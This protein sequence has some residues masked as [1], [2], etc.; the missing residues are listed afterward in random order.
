MSKKHKVLV[1][2][3][4]FGGV[5]A[6]QELS[7]DYTLEVTLLS[8]DSELRYYPTLF[9]TATGGSRANSSIPFTTIFEGYNLTIKKGLATSLDRHNKT[10]TTKDDQVFKYDTL[11]LA[12]GVVTNYFN[13]EGMKEYSYS[14][15]SQQEASE[16]KR[17]IHKQLSQTHRPDPNYIV[18]GAGPTGIE[19]A[20]TLPE[21]I[22]HVM[23]RHGLQPRKV[24]VDLVEAAPRL[25]P[26]STPQVS[27]IL[28][29]RM[30]RLGV[31]IY[32]NSTV[33][34][35]DANNLK[36]EG[37]PIRSHT[38]IWT[39]GVT[40]NPFFKNNNFVIS[41]HGK[42]AVNVYLQA[43]DN[44][45]VLGDNANTPYS[46][47]AQTALL[48]GKFVADNLKR[49]L[50]NKTMKSYKAMLPVSIVPAGKHW[51]IVIWGGIVMSGWLGWLLREA[52][53]FVGFRDLESWPKASKQFLSE[54]TQD[55]ECVACNRAIENPLYW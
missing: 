23:K 14:I 18:I 28:A 27:R 15:K 22:G 29:R 48:D 13:I 2:G 3:G 4:G 30:K 52:A 39:A 12:L 16:L 41:Q 53:D 54:F 42:V 25:M 17:H 49:H 38:V 51:A 45:Y 37:K 11:I 50:R 47:L 40:N 5:K 10:I 36:I 8:D 19:L 6:A 9:H 33:T 55:N 44:I 31:K 35:L 34:G 21:Y 43:E 20:G 7:K 24:H 26:S 32:C 46:G 1:V